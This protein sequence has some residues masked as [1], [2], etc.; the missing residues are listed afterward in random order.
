MI[1]S[2]GS[3]VIFDSKKDPVIKDPFCSVFFEVVCQDDEGLPHIYTSNFL[4]NSSRRQSLFHRGSLHFV[5]LTIGHRTN[6]L[7]N[8]FLVNRA[9]RVFWISASHSNNTCCTPGT[10]TLLSPL[11]FWYFDFDGST[12]IS[13]LLSLF[14]DCSEHFYQ[15]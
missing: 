15:A 2:F 11:G 9:V 6:C 4:S 10:V 12:S 7:L 13:L 3:P 14:I 5:L 1:W 8:I